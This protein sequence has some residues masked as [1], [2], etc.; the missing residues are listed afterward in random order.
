MIF[1]IQKIS[2]Y[3]IVRHHLY[4]VVTEKQS[5]VQHSNVSGKQKLCGWTQ[6]IFTQRTFL[7]DV[8]SY[9]AG[10]NTYEFKTF[11]NDAYDIQ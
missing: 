3:F 9:W 10:L 2:V 5:F 6:I 11:Y 1:N 8:F 7:I 4:I